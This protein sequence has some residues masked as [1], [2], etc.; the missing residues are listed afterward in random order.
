MGCAPAYCYPEN[1][2]RMLCAALLLVTT[3]VA[4]TPAEDQVRFTSLHEQA[5]KSYAAKDY[6][7]METALR[8]ADTLRPRHGRTLYNL[9]AARALLGD[10]KGAVGLLTRLVELRLGYKA[11]EDADFA[12][13]KEDP[14][15]TA[16]AERLRRNLKPRGRPQLTFQA[17]K[18]SFLPEGIA[19][20]R[21]R[22][23][24]Y[25]G[26][27]R[28]RRILQVDRSMERSTFKAT[29]ENGLYSVLG[30]RY[31]PTTNRLWVASAALPEMQG[32]DKDEDAGR[33]GLW[34]FDVRTSNLRGRFLLPKDDKAHAL[35]DLI[36]GSK[37]TIYTTDSLGGTLYSLDRVKSKFTALTAPGAL[38]SPQGLSF[39]KDRKRI[40]LADYS[41][42]LFVYDIEAK[43]LKPLGLSD[44]LSPYGIDGLYFY[45]DNL[46][47]IQNGVRPYRII[48]MRLN[49]A[50]D[51]ITQTD[52]LAANHP[53]WD[54]P[55]LGVME[56]GILYF[57]ANSHWN[58][59]D[60]KHRLP[61]EDLLSRPL[62][63]RLDVRIKEE[64]ETE[65]VSELKDRPKS[66]E[67]D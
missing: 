66:V 29:G 10:A 26:S 7:A 12:A 13:L 18:A 51:A 28:Q 16:V 6:A 55:T 36:I 30:M 64:D 21:E 11:D 63:M 46:I 59:V 65:P 8:E 42:G 40:Y 25:I 17:G 58:R 15:F 43:T 44:N 33:S 34:A 19:Y 5:L 2:M 22:D 50:G 61:P 54:E 37:G 41:L 4:A 35:G 56:R 14:A 62:V 1:P 27:V 53:D 3:A 23:N 38:V 20:D 49:D 52:V 48:R 9:A 32:Y 57:V 45:D 39:S 67:G 47:A 31:E 24:F 60:E